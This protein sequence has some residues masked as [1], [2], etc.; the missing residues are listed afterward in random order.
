MVLDLNK[1][2]EESLQKQIEKILVAQK[3]EKK[4]HQWNKF[5]GKVRRIK[6]PV[7]YQRT[8]RDE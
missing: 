2:S 1:N 4:K 3:T 8:L 7:A 5:F 6:D